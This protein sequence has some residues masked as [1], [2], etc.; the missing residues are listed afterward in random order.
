M[1]TN[2]INL[3]SIMTSSQPFYLY[4]D[5]MFMITVSVVVIIESGVVMI[6]EEPILRPELEDLVTV[7]Q[8]QIAYDCFRFPG[9]KVK[10]EQET[11]QFS[12]IRQLKEQTGLTIKKEDLVPVD[13]R[14]DPERSHSKNIIDIGMVCMPNV[15]PDFQF[16]EGSKLI[17]IDFDRKT[18]SYTCK[19]N[20]GFYMDHDVLLE[21]ATDI[22][23]MMK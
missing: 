18:F 19:L 22:A 1:E 6:V 11:I 16:K 8:T 15:S 14:S 9:G 3:N 12:A 4:K 17:P 21:R 10:A 5:P 7:D 13:F 20:Y 2:N 23:L